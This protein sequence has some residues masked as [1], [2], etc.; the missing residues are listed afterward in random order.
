MEDRRVGI[1]DSVEPGSWDVLGG[2]GTIRS[3]N[4]TL[5]IRNSVEV[6]EQIAGYFALGR[7]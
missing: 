3:Y 7:H 1:E 4:R 5:V 6:H 2:R